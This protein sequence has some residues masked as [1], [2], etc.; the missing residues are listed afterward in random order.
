MQVDFDYNG[1]GPGISKGL[2]DL[3]PERQAQIEYWQYSPS[4][5]NLTS[6]GVVV[7]LP[8]AF[9]TLRHFAPIA[10]FVQRLGFSALLLNHRGVG[11]SMATSSEKL[12]TKSMALDAAALVGKLFSGSERFHLVGSS[13]GGM[14]A[15]HLA[16]ILLESNRLA[17]LFLAVSTSQFS[18]AH[19]L[20]GALPGF[21]FLPIAATTLNLSPGELV[22]KCLCPEYRDSTVRVVNNGV[23]STS[24]VGNI[25]LKRF[26]ENFDDWFT[27]RN[28]S[29]SDNKWLP[30]V[31]TTARMK[32]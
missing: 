19:F 23:E 15:Q 26:E 24:S 16:A 9:S 3:R 8:G 21:L 6:N 11:A 22:D 29:L 32:F 18:D 31:H 2:C 25:W 28:S 30:Q 20:I 1:L 13:M 27:F 5:S 17:S 12:T 7:V 4:P 10:A 14:V